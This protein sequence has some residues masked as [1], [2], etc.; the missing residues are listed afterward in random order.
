[1]EIALGSCQT[2]T[3]SG[4]QEFLKAL[5]KQEQENS[6]RARREN[7]VTVQVIES[8]EEVRKLEKYI[9]DKL[10]AH[11]IEELHHSANASL[12]DR[13]KQGDKSVVPEIIRILKGNDA[14]ARKELY[15]G[16]IGYNVLENYQIAENDLVDAI[17]NNISKSSDEEHVVQLAGNMKLKG[18]G[19]VF[20]QRLFSKKSSAEDRLIY[21]LGIDGQSASTLSYIKKLMRNIR[22]LWMH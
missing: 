9:T 22:T 16:L 3:K 8:S 13:Y 5:F 18:Y 15:E 2:T 6:E 21:W 19:P 20:E 7:E 14:D 12:S 10:E 11:R 4:D 17:F 1:M